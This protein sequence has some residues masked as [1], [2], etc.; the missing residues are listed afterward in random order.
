MTSH[1]LSVAAESESKL[2]AVYLYH[3]RTKHHVDRYARALGY[4]DW[5]SQ[6]N[7]FR[8]FE[9]AQLIPNPLPLPRIEAE[10]T[11][12]AILA[13]APTLAPIGIE[14][15]SNLFF[16]SLALS[17]WKQVTGLDGQV[18]SRWS[19]R[20]NPS[21][22]NLHPTEGYL[23]SG[24]VPGL[25]Q[26]PG[27][28]HYA[29]FE[30]GLE[31]RR[32]LTDAEWRIL[33]P[34]LPPGACLLGLTSIYWRESWKYGERA[35]RYCQH[36]VGHA[37]GAVTIS[38]GSLGWRTRLLERVSTPALERLL[39]ID[40]QQGIEAEHGDCLLLLH[41]GGEGVP[42]FAP[43]EALLAKL[44]DGEWLGEPNH[45][46]SQHHPWPVIDD[47]SEACT[48]PGAAPVEGTEAP[49]GLRLP[50]ERGL[51][52]YRLIRQRRSAV[53]LDGRTTISSGTFYRML[54][55]VMP[56][57][58]PI[59]FAT[60][61]W[62]PTV[63]LVLFVHRVS[64][65]VEGLY[66]LVRHLEHLQSLRRSLGPDLIWGKPEG[67][68]QSLPLYLLLTGDE[69]AIAR[70][71][72]CDQEIAADGV[73]SVG[74]LAAFDEA[75]SAAGPGMYPRMFWETGVIG[76]TLYL[77]A[78]AARIRATGI[79]CFYDDE[80][81]R[82]LGIKDHSWQSLY[83]FTMGGAVEDPRLQSLDA[84]GHLSDDRRTTAATGRVK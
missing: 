56:E 3:D 75:L 23:I 51:S 68:P 53:A 28:Y 57:A 2:E 17:A 62:R 12:D 26:F 34:L 36:D 10:P 65:L 7:P 33:S 84:Y 4:M 79:G 67:C 82:I 77:E 39:G 38:A 35:F 48:W 14:T 52:A 54:Q 30:H 11:Y 49:S 76:Q 41:P 32:R 40:Q 1:P 63:S 46:S 71:V 16:F 60:L 8:R 80:V 20:V 59:P 45:L 58:N 24:P 29:P 43:P 70:A 37:I 50:G 5:A 47:V 6:P 15:I 72:S 22:G 69:R 81:H 83:H 21:S 19:L 9:S 66:V 74:M 42:D 18:G 61:P 73:F 27:I 78:E 64:G 25:A 44:A 31:L 13:A 55:N